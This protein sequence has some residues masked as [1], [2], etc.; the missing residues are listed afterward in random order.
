[1]A[2]QSSSE[3]I[4]VCFPFCCLG[5][6]EPSK[7]VFF[8]VMWDIF[9]FVAW[10]IYNLVLMDE[11]TV[12]P[13]I[14]SFIFIL[15]LFPVVWDIRDPWGKFYILRYYRYVR[16]VQASLMSAAGLIFFILIFV[17]IANSTLEGTLMTKYMALGL[18]IFLLP[19]SVIHWGTVVTMHRALRMMRSNRLHDETNKGLSLT[20]NKLNQTNSSMIM[21]PKGNNT[22]LET[23]SRLGQL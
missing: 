13:L 10:F 4:R 6:I 2:F 14:I 7:M 23:T 16:I 19:S 8:T 11:I 15:L 1:M 3:E 20:L 18:F 9:V 21:P 17:Y 22:R 5:T 12:A